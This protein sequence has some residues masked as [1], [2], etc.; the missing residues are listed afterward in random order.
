MYGVVIAVSPD[1]GELIVAARH[2]HRTE[3]P[4]T[5]PVRA[6]DQGDGIVLPDL[7]LNA[8]VT[9]RSKHRVLAPDELRE[10]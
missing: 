7:L 6:D 9:T 3:L 1:V 2:H 8:V 10:S 4:H 5:L